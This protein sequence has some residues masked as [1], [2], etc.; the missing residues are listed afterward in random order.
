MVALTSLK[1]EKKKNGMIPLGS[2]KKV[3]I[4]HGIRWR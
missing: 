2:E 3:C 4:M 1:K